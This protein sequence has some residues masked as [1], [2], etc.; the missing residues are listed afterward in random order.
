MLMR[1]IVDTR[2]Y[3]SDIARILIQP[4]LDPLDKSTTEAQISLARSLGLDKIGEG[5]REGT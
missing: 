4:Y 3:Q 2:C 5:V 1:I